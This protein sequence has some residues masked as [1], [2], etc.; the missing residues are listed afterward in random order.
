MEGGPL[1]STTLRL[2][3]RKY[4]QVEIGMYTH[5]SCFVPGNFDRYTKIGRYCSIAADVHVFNRNHP[6]DFKS[7]HAFFFNPALKFTDRDLVEYTPLEIGND[8][9]IGHGAIILPHVTTIG[10]GAVIGAGAVVCINVPPF[11][12]VVGN[13]ARVVRYRFPRETIEQLLKEKWW[14]KDIKDILPDIKEYQRPYGKEDGVFHY[15]TK[16][17]SDHERPA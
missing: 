10:D 2:I 12:V 8:V 11:A 16:R 15:E 4:Y 7:M 5:G 1:Y 13:P 17:K 6:M 9:W 14:E 3:F